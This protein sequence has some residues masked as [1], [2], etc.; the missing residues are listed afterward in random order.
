MFAQ[1]N[2]ACIL[3]VRNDV[4]W[5]NRAV[6]EGPVQ[7]HLSLS[8][9]S[10]L[11]E[12]HDIFMDCVWVAYWFQRTGVTFVG[13][14]VPLVEGNRKREPLL[15]ELK[16]LAFSLSCFATLSLLRRVVSRATG[17]TFSRRTPVQGWEDPLCCCVP[18][19]VTVLGSHVSWFVVALPQLGEL[20]FSG[21]QIASVLRSLQCL[22]S[23]SCSGLS[24]LILLRGWELMVTRP[25]LP[26]GATFSREGTKQHNRGQGCK[27]RGKKMQSQ[28][29]TE[30]NNIKLREGQCLD[31]REGR[32]RT[33]GC[34]VEEI[35]L[36]FPE[37]HFF[38]G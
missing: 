30:Q 27:K 36:L 4:S 37:L 23:L 33:R 28:H 10:R 25:S 6:K 31:R 1:M 22:L 16:E 20:S 2:P 29:R 17:S 13:T 14:L 11:F 21:L 15:P 34:K 19:L 12:E 18:W 5:P 8:P 38:P 9:P 35:C 26:V 24:F 32:M 7:L 3:C